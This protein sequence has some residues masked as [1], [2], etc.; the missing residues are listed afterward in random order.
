MR[1]VHIVGNRPFGF[2]IPQPA[3]A[4][5]VVH[6]WRLPLDV[7]HDFLRN[8]YGFLSSDERNRAERF[9]FEV[10]KHR[11]V[12]G[13]GLLRLI[14]GYYCNVYPKTLQFIY[15]RNGK[16]A[17]KR[18]GATWP[19]AGALHFNLAHSDAFGV[20]AVTASGPVGVDVE[21]VRRLSDFNELVTRFFSPEEA[22]E[23][24]IVP[25]EEQPVAFFNLWTRKEALLKATGAGILDPLATFR[26]TF[27]P[28]IPAHVLSFPGNA[29][30]SS[31]WSLFDLGISP[32]LA[33]ALA[34][35]FGTASVFEYR[36]RDLN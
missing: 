3:L 22:A 33:G 35:S 23:F 24:S 12:A 8:F 4:E 30:A 1:Q 2:D 19:I 16:P 34:F 18:E 21:R 17:L 7:G 13:R 14:L 36:L 15:G 27:R 6:L 29:F 32:S 26:V 25:W 20:L 10:D 11:F 28:G 31:E 5:R 9:R